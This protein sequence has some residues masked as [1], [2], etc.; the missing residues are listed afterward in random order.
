MTALIKPFNDDL[1]FADAAADEMIEAGDGRHLFYEELKQIHLALKTGC[2]EE[3]D[4][5]TLNDILTH[6]DRLIGV[7]NR[8]PP[9]RKSRLIV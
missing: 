4:D 5:E 2:P 6:P 3:L 1:E 8:I 9:S 7:I